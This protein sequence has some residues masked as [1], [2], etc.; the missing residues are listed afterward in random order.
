MRRDWRC[1]EAG[2]E[3]STILPALKG[4]EMRDDR[5]GYIVRVKKRIHGIG[6]RGIMYRFRG[7]FFRS[8][9]RIPLFTI[10]SRVTFVNEKNQKSLFYIKHF[11][12]RGRIF[13]Q[14]LNT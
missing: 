11:L 9:I 7:S 14:F 10:D 12:Q 1:P 13:C 5:R 4:H 6:R 8:F 3:R 2:A